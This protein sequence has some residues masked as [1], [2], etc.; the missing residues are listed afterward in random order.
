MDWTSSSLQP[1]EVIE[2]QPKLS[3]LIDFRVVLRGG[4]AMRTTDI[5]G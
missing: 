5:Y 2:H 1:E 4:S 3:D